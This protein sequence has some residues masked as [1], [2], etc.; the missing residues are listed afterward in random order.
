MF[1]KSIFVAALATLALGGVIK[2]DDNRREAIIPKN[3]T[4]AQFTVAW[5]AEC[6]SL[7]Y[8]SEGGVYTNAS[9]VEAAPTAGDANV[10][11]SWYTERPT[12]VYDRTAECG[13][14]LGVQF[15]S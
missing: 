7:F 4:L 1:T 11:C 5:K 6:D 8:A 14:A 3:E 2:R 10:Y 13:E 9:L 15:T 12:I